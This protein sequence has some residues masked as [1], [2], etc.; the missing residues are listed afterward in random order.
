MSGDPYY[1]ENCARG[2]VYGAPEGQV[3][4]SADKSVRVAQVIIT[5]NVVAGDGTK[6]NP[7]RLITQV[8]SMDGDLIAERDPYAIVRPQAE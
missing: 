6:G 8:W 7:I 2:G 5:N 3:V 4:K 1:F